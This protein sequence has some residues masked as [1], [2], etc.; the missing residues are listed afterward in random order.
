MTVKPILTLSIALLT[1]SVTL[2]E[3]TNTQK[4]SDETLRKIEAFNNNR[5]AYKQ[6]LNE[7]TVILDPPAPR[8]I[9]ILPPAEVIEKKPSKPVLVSG[10]RP[11]DSAPSTPDDGLRIH[12]EEIKTGN[13]TIAP[14][15]IRLKTKFAPKPLASPPA[16]WRLD[17]QDQTPAITQ[18][19]E[20]EPGIV[21]SLSIQ[22]HTLTPI[23]DGSTSFSLP[24]I[25]FNPDNEYSTNHHHQ[26]HPRR[27]HR[28]TRRRFKT[29]RKRFERSPAPACVSS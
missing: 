2:A 28:A 25:G 13:G 14:E 27:F 21:I 18:E 12:V 17:L 6:A 9:P 24:E 10:T 22:P 5:A 15:S 26:R 19:V 3:N 11:S 16:N 7:V 1:P 8:S 20:I 4:F 23:T 29:V